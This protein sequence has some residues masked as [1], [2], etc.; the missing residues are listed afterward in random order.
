MLLGQ[1]RAYDVGGVAPAND[2]GEELKLLEQPPLQRK[3]WRRRQNRRHRK[4]QA[5]GNPEQDCR[6]SSSMTAVTKIDAA[7]Y[8]VAV[9]IAMGAGEHCLNG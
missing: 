6:L 3:G 9:Q 7:G 4:M 8:A 5:E 1:F 2:A